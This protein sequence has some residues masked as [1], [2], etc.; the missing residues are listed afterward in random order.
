MLLPNQIPLPS[1]LG[2][3]V[4]LTSE[5]CLKGLP[6]A[7]QQNASQSVTGLSSPSNSSSS[8]AFSPSGNSSTPTSSNSQ[9]QS[10]A[11]ASPSSNSNELADFKVG[12]MESGKIEN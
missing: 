1:L 6:R 11:N 12:K 9:G 8:T 4:A 5:R 3:R 7:A 2:V 10:A